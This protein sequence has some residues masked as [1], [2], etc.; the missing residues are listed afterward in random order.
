[1]MQAF[2]KLEALVYIYDHRS[3]DF[4]IDVPAVLKFEKLLPS[5][6]EKY[7]PPLT[8][9]ISNV[10]FTLCHQAYLKNNP[11]GSLEDFQG[12]F[13]TTPAGVTAYQ[14]ALNLVGDRIKKVLSVEDIEGLY[15][16]PTETPPV[17]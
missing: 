6:L 13:L 2:Q 4:H 15:K 7:T 1:M 12:S 17:A 11:K 8:A 10:A 9:R 16:T 5:V 14:E 3:V